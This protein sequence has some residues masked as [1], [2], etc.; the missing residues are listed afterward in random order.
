MTPFLFV[1]YTVIINS[2]PFFNSIQTYFIFY[3]HVLTIKIKT[4]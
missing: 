1:I 2:Y 4:Q 3:L